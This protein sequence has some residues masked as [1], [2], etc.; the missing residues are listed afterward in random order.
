MKTLVTALL[1]VLAVPA[2]AADVVWVTEDT[3]SV[4]FADADTP[5]PTF[6]AFSRL[7]VLYEDGD[8]YRVKEANAMNWGWIPKAG[9]TAEEPPEAKTEELPEGALPD[10]QKMLEEIEARQP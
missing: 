7:V 9:T 6:T 8:R 3:P 2:Y 10:F 1:V 5:G 4:R